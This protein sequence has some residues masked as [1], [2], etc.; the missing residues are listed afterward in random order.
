MGYVV[1]AQRV[2]IEVKRIEV[3]ENWPKIK[4]VKDIQMFLRFP[5][6][7]YYFI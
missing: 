1:S 2:K 7:H 4:L 6:F 5:N 3:V